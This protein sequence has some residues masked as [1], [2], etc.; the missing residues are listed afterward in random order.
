MN[1]SSTS[2]LATLVASAALLAPSAASAATLAGTVVQS[3]A[4]SHSFVI[5]TRGG[6]LSEVHARHQPGIGRHVVVSAVKLRNGTW[7]ARRVHQSG[8]RQ[9]ARI[10]GTVT[11]SSARAQTFVVSARG[12]SLLV[13]RHPRHRAG[14][15]FAAIAT[16]STGSLPAV[17]DDVTVSAEL[18]GGDVTATEVSDQ[19]T[20]SNG[21]DLEGVVLG[22]DMT[23]STISISADD[24]EQ[25]SASLTVDVPQS[26]SMTQFNIGDKVELI[27]SLNPDGSYTLEQSSGDES[28]QQADNPGDQQGNDNSDQQPSAAQ[29][30]T[31][32]ASDP[33]FSATHNGETFAQYYAINPNEPNNA[34]GDCVDTLSSDGGTQSSPQQQCLAQ[35]ADPNF[36]ATHNG[37]T[38]LQYYSTNPN[39]ISSGDAFG[40]CLDV[41]HQQDS[42]QSGGS[43]G[44]P[45][46]SAGSGD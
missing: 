11:Y 43:D 12:V 39:E 25:S 4:S 8:L 21:I 27:V 31:T 2:M 28:A 45:G 13:H 34:F 37:E 33:N 38:F 9:S 3:N 10:H 20:N 29:Q 44:A 19:G 6:H 42:P 30:C 15:V 32:Q 16:A 23:A 14:D 18:T 35:R 26:F 1:R 40:H 41:M 46:S 24:S 5:A 7:A 22:V 17:G 36:P